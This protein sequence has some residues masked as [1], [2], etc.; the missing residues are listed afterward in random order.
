MYLRR[1]FCRLPLLLLTGCIGASTPGATTCATTSPEP[2][3]PPI[4]TA[5]NG[6]PTSTPHP[7]F[8]PP[9]PTITI[10]S[11]PTLSAPLATCPP[12]PRPTVRCFNVTGEGPSIPY[13]M[14]SF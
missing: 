3:M 6:I 9:T 11:R 5:T 13:G 1:L 10:L 4:A 12:E 7:S 14:I 8:N 2:T